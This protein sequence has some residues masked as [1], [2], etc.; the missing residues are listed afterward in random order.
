M[1]SYPIPPVS[2]PIPAGE[3]VSGRPHIPRKMLIIVVAV[4]I[5]GML[6]GGVAAAAIGVSFASTERV[7]FGETTVAQTALDVL[8]VEVVGPGINVHEVQVTI[9][10]P[11]TSAIDA[12]VSVYLMSGTT[13]ISD[14][15]VTHTFGATST[16]TVSVDVDNVREHQ[17]DA[18]DLRVK[19]T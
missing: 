7:T 14:G 16:E 11:T 17:Y 18:I 12:E 8:N 10:N 3:G 19:E 9:E 13:V 5:S 6:L 4:L 2:T 15:S 1:V